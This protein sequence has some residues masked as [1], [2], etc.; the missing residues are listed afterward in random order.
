[1]PKRKNYRLQPLLRIKQQAKR[2]TEIAL[3]KAIVKLEEEK[4]KKEKLEEEKAKIVQK[5]KDARQKMY[6]K[7]LAGTSVVHDNNVHVNYIRK[8]EEDRKAKDREI[9]EQVEVIKAAEKAVARAR[10]DYIDA[11]KE[12]QVM[13]KHKELWQKKVQKEITQR[14]EREMDE[15]GNVIHQLKNMNAA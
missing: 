13:E 12:L 1:M 10:R 15:L 4:K 8:L 14:E 2:R 7:M 5:K 6:D 9:E 11:A 3:A